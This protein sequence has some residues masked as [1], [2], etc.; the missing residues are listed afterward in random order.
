[1]HDAYASRKQD[2]IGR[3]IKGQTTGA[4][5]ARRPSL[6]MPS[7]SGR[8]DA[9]AKALTRRQWGGPFEALAYVCGRDALFWYRAGLACGRPSLV[10]TTGQDPPQGP[11]AL[12]ADETLPQVATQHVAVPPTV[13]GGC[14]L[15][16]SVG[17]AAATVRLERG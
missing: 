16:R 17:E 10:G 8:T 12:V 14:C 1:M 11:R 15:G 4:V 3:R 9:I 2:V 5:F 6:L 7:L 13:G